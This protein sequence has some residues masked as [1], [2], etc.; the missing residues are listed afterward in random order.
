MVFFES[1]QSISKR[2]L[3]EDATVGTG[4]FIDWFFMSAL[5]FGLLN[6]VYL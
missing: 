2:P 1:R 6:F 5:N 3:I 4:A